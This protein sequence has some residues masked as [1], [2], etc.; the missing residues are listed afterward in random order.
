MAFL[1]MHQLSIMLFMSGICGILAFETLLT[2]SLQGKRKSVLALMEL[3]AMLLLMFDRYAYLYRGNPSELGYV[4]V[5]VSNGAV[6]FLSLFIPHLVTQYLRD[7]F[8]TEGKMHTAPRRL[9]LCDAL[10]VLGTVLLAVSQFTGLYYTFDAQNTYH[11]AS[12]YVICFVI[13]LSLVL[14]QLSAVIR[15]RERLGG[16]IANALLISLSLPAVA[17]LAQ[18][19]FYGVS[20]ANMTMASVVSA[21]YIYALRELSKTV[22]QAQNREL[23]FYKEAR[24]REYTMLVQTAEALANAIDTKDAY[25]R[26]HSGRVAKYSRQI[27]KAAGFQDTECKQI[28][29][30]ALLHDVGKIGVRDEIINKAGKLTDEEFEEIKQHPVYGDQILSSIKQSPYLSVGAR[31]HHERYDGKGYPDGL[32]GEDIP[33]YARIIA[34]ADAYDAMTSRRSYRDPLPRETVRSELVNGIGKQFDPK[35]AK[36]MLRLMDSGSV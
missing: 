36:I 5:R 15:Y 12:G 33:D 11:R 20:L 2:E 26:G 9:L 16:G 22:K 18:M 13:P 28:S 4:M 8:M 10:F 32:A 17:S 29:F 23:M 27:A 34:V 24:E 14:S 21:F 1:R 19:V 30:A 25:T 6:F 31:W 3:S 35:Y 7:M